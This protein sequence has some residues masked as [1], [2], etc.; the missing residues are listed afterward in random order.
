MDQEGFREMLRK[1]KLAD[2]KIEASILLAERFEAYISASGGK[3]DADTTWA[4]CKLLIQEEQNTY[5]NLLTLARYGRFI[6]NNE[7]YIAVLELLDGEEAQRN[8]YQ[9]VGERFGGSVRDEVFAGIGLAPLGIPTP[10]KP[11]FLF[12]V[13]DRLIDQV[14][15]REVERL[16]SA[17]L[18]DL[19]DEYFRNERRKYLKSRD[20][21]DYLV[22]KHRS[23]VRWIRKCQREGELFF[24]Q[25]I[26]DDV[27]KLVRENQ[28]IESGVRDGN[29]VYVTK[30]PYNAK[31]YLAETDPTLKRYYA[32]HCPW[33]RAAIKGGEASLNAAFCNCSGG[34][35]KKPWEVIF[36]QTLEVE[37]LESV[38]RGDTRCRFAIHLPEK[39]EIAS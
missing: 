19:P 32:C 24:A 7:I 4:F 30:I 21:D 1:R 20:I 8:L 22:K 38:L 3:P 35:H 28:E 16:L 9:K 26:T 5:D 23:F 31:D 29:L 6:K 17:C 36:R 25:E 12:P 18:R 14:G 37:V 33:A 15:Q 34:F 11:G 13:I 10:E 27:V 2:E 39:L